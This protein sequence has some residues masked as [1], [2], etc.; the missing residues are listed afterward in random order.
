M[1]RLRANWRLSILL[2][3]IPVLVLATLQL[4][5][6]VALARSC[7]TDCRDEYTYCRDDCDDEYEE[8]LGQ[9]DPWQCM[10]EKFECRDQCEIAWDD[11]LFECGS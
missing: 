5:A 9:R 1:N 6:G 10:Q 11:C 7:A 3:A 2:L 4:S 8:C